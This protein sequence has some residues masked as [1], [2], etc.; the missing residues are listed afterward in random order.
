MTNLFPFEVV[1][2]LAGLFSRE[3]LDNDLIPYGK[4]TPYLPGE[5]SAN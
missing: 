3:F 1:Y 4:K 2:T 5:F